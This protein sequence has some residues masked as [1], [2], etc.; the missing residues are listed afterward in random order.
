[1]KK[2]ILL[3]VLISCASISAHQVWFTTG[4][5]T[6]LEDLYL[7][8]DLIVLS[9]APNANQSGVP[10]PASS[11][12][13]ITWSMDT[14]D[15]AQANALQYK[16][17]IDGV[18]NSLVHKCGDVKPFNC[19]APLPAMTVGTHTIDITA[20]DATSESGHSTSIVVRFFIVLVTP[21][22][23]KILVP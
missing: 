13:L 12:A 2:L 10:I 17:Y 4:V 9:L 11:K 3:F 1:M 22:N 19:T 7:P 6:K 21:T 14:D 18:A 5:D 8:E 23:L 16:M 20:S 15:L